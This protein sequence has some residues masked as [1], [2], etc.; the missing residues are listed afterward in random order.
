M[1]VHHLNIKYNRQNI[2]NR[3]TDFKAYNVQ[4]HILH[5][6]LLAVIHT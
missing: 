1:L 4:V 6:K 5:K 2:L 3:S